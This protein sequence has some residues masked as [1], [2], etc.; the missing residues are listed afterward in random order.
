M[1]FIVRHIKWIMLFSGALTCT[2]IYA[3]ISPENALESTFGE[4]ID[5]SLANLVVRSWGGLITLIGS[6]LIY[7]AFNPA[8]R[9]FA[10]TIAATSKILYV[11]LVVIFGSQY[12]NKAGLVIGFDSVVAILLF[13]YIYAAKRRT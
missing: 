3:V 9:T 4:S 2:M 12:L 11:A 10:A 5:G 7:G 13:L 6:M 1:D 8:V